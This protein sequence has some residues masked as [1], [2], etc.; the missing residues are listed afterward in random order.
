MLRG[1]LTMLCHASRASRSSSLRW[2]LSFFDDRP[3]RVMAIV[4]PVVGQD[5]Q[6]LGLVHVGHDRRTGKS[7]DDGTHLVRGVLSYPIDQLLF[8]ADVIGDVLGPLLRPLLF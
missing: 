5:P 3:G 8:R 4:R 6:A 1:F 7:V 2:T